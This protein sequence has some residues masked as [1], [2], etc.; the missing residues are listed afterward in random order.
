MSLA[1]SAV[2]KTSYTEL[3]L[4]EP[5]FCQCRGTITLLRPREAPEGKNS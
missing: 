4:P 1:P 3:T 5:P 2:S